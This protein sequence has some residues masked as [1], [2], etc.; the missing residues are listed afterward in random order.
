MSPPSEFFLTELDDELSEQ[1]ATLGFKVPRKRPGVVKRFLGAIGGFFVGIYARIVWHLWG[2]KA[3]VAR[4]ENERERMKQLAGIGPDP[5]AGVTG[6]AP[7][8]QTYGTSVMPFEVPQASPVTPPQV[9]DKVAVDYRVTLG[10]PYLVGPD[11][12]KVEAVAALPIPTKRKRSSSS[13]KK[14]STKKGSRR[15]SRGKSSR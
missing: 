11:G 12:S 10:K 6:N 9:T 15:S 7:L 13:S 4:L 2:K 3:L 5:T 14:K 8:T 1:L